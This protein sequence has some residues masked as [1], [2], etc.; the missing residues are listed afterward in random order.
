MHIKTA[1]LK[2]V[3][4]AAAKKDIRCY[5]K[6]VLIN[7]RHI[8]ATDGSRLHAARHGAEW[9]HGPR[10]IPID[11]LLLALKKKS[12]LTEITLCSVGDVI[13]APVDGV[14]PAY[15]R[16]LPR[17]TEPEQ[18]P[19]VMNINPKYLADACEAIKLA[20]GES[21]TLAF[22]GGNWVYSSA[23]LAITVS[24]TRPTQKFPSLTRLEPFQ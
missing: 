20:T 21:H 1:I 4:L 24:P 19:G 2:A 5:L 6:G 18:C 11:N 16:V 14:F 15:E 22:S 23:L 7:D 8:V 17:G 13:Y 9:L 3:S 10:I 12:D